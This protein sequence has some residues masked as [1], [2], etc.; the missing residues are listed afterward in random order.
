MR[1]LYI[2][3]MRFDPEQG[4]V[5]RTTYKLSSQF[6][7]EGV[8]NAIL[9]PGWVDSHYTS[10]VTRFDLKVGDPSTYD[11]SI[12]LALHEFKPDVVINQ[13]PHDLNI[14]NSLGRLR[15]GFQCLLIGC[16]RNSLFSVKNNL[17]T[18]ARV[19]F[20]LPV[21]LAKWRL[22]Q[23]IGL[24][25][26]FYK[27]RSVLKKILDYHD[28]FILLTQANVD[29]LR[30][31]VGTY[32]AEK[33]GVIPNSI[34]RINSADKKE[35]RLLYVG[36]LVSEQKRAEHLIPLWQE[37]HQNMPDWEFDIVGD[38]PLQKTMQEEIENSKLPR[39]NVLGKQNPSNYYSRSKLFV[40]TSAFEGFPNVLI[41][42][43]SFGS[44]PVCYNSYGAISEIM[45]HEEEGILVDDQQLSDLGKAIEALSKD[46]QRL[47]EYSNRALAKA[48]KFTIEKVIKIWFEEFAFNG[49][50][51]NSV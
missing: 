9:S 31:F 35:K 42:G 17:E 38:G 25:M 33:V 45:V 37:I 5:Q 6:A 28:R 15:E 34:P 43:M 27:H 36:R 29:E 19:A 21:G 46:D 14:T 32:K 39:I 47:E 2:L 40:M 23:W 51:S 7:K 22:F 26:H 49:I 20:K 41:E 30:Y 48:E 24:K 3:G 10:H 13:M 44:V 50:K 18:Y 11:E 1:I 12:R 4:G 8:E 16:L